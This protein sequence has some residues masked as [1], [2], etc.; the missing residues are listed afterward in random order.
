MDIR[1]TVTY[2]VL[3]NRA[4]LLDQIKLPI[5]YYL[6][7]TYYVLRYTV[8]QLLPTRYYMQ[9]R[10]SSFMEFREIFHPTRLLDTFF[11]YSFNDFLPKSSPPRLL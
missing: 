3:K 2:N 9:Y 10:P 5:S 6:H 7:S 4:I 11:P 8:L 1:I